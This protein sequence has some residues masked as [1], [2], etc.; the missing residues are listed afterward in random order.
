[1]VQLHTAPWALSSASHALLLSSHLHARPQSR[2]RAAHPLPVLAVRPLHQLPQAQAI[3]VPVH[4]VGHREAAL[5]VVPAKRGGGGLAAVGH[6]S[7]SKR[8]RAAGQRPPCVQPKA[9]R[10]GW[11]MRTPAPPPRHRAA[12]QLLHSRPSPTA[13]PHQPP[14][15]AGRGAAP[16]GHRHRASGQQGQATGPHPPHTNAA[17]GKH[18]WGA[19]P[20]SRACGCQRPRHCRGRPLGH[21]HPT[22]MQQPASKC[23]R[24]AP[25]PTPVSVGGHG[26][27]GA[28]RWATPTPRRCSSWQACVGGKPLLPR[29]WVWAATA[30][31]GQAAGQHWDAATGKLVREA[32]PT[33]PP[34]VDV[35]GQEGQAGHRA[36]AR[37]EHKVHVGDGVQVRGQ[38]EHVDV[39]LQRGSA[40]GALQHG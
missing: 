11:G 17:T 13:A 5:R 12:A 21:T 35:G 10:G 1:M 37:V 7:R 38:R 9:M 25:P 30:L 14:L 18:V 22:R 4:Q 39:R 3:V 15:H 26:P 8:G 28:G 34:P 2:R 20:S 33:A 19:S 31:Q 29:L 27:A 23:E 16:Q 32:G 36:V 40:H 24:E 6:V